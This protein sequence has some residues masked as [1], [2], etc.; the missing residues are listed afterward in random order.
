MNGAPGASDRGGVGSPQRKVHVGAGHPRNG[1]APGNGNS[2][3]K[4]A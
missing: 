4:R 2:R 3:G 1:Q